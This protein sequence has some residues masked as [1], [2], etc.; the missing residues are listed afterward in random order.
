MTARRRKLER[1]NDDDDNGDD[2]DDDDNIL[3]ANAKNA[4]SGQQRSYEKFRKKNKKTKD[5]QKM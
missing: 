4:P 2:D 5:K 3:E 1:D